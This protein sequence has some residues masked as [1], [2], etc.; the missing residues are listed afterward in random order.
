MDI[1]YSLICASLEHD[2]GR[3]HMNELLDADDRYEKDPSTLNK[4]D[5]IT[6]AA[7]YATLL[8]RHI[9]KEDEVVYTFA[10]RA[11]SA[12]D[13]ERVD[14]ETKAFDEDPENKA[15]VAKYL[16]WFEG[17]RAKYPAR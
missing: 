3:L 6:N 9:G 5:I 2:L 15:N 12:E 14:A 17:F 1:I 4:L 7:G 13:K 11:L 8:N 16:E 10:E